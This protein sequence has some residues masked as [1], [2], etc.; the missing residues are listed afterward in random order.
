[1][2]LSEKIFTFFLFHHFSNK[3][4]NLCLHLNSQLSSFEIIISRCKS[5]NKTQSSE[6][7]SVDKLSSFIFF[8]F[9]SVFFCFVFFFL[10]NETIFFL[11]L[12]LSFPQ[13]KLLTITGELDEKKNESTKTKFENFCNDFLYL[14]PPSIVQVNEC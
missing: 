10:F 6:F 9:F 1:M 2:E 8:S 4:T 13:V 11:L 3:T 7:F 14:S 5:K 12:F